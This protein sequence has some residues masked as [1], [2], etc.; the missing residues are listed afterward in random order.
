[1]CIPSGIAAIKHIDEKMGRN[2]HIENQHNMPGEV[3]GGLTSRLL[4]G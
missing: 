3:C 2:T 1:M 4:G